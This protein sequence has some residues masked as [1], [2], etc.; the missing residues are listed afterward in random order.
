MKMK[1]KSKS[2]P[3]PYFMQIGEGFTFSAIYRLKSPD[4][5]W[6][7]GGKDIKI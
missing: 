1:I 7:V 5:R 2:L 3:Q 4:S 6:K